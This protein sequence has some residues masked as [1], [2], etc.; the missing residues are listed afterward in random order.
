MFKHFLTII[1][2]IFS[3]TLINGAA[4]RVT[5]TNNT[6]G[7]NNVSF[8]FDIDT[9]NTTIALMQIWLD[10]SAFTDFDLS[11]PALDALGN[12]TLSGF[13]S[14]PTL[15]VADNVSKRITFSNCEWAWGTTITITL[16]A[17]VINNT[18][19]E[20]QSITVGSDSVRI[21]KGPVSHT[22]YNYV[23]ITGVNTVDSNGNGKI[24]RLR[25][26]TNSPNNIV[27]SGSGSFAYTVSGYT[28]A[29]TFV[30]N[31]TD[32]Y[33]TFNEGGGLD[34][35][36]TPA[37]TLSTNT[38]YWDAT[39]K[40]MVETGAQPGDYPATTDGAAPIITAAVTEDTNNDGYIDRITLTYYENVVSNNNWG[41]TYAGSSN[42]LTTSTVGAATNTV[43]LTFT[44]SAGSYDTAETP[45]VIYNTFSGNI[46]DTNGVAAP[47]QTFSATTDGAAPIII[48]SSTGD[49]NNDGYI[50]TITLTYSED[51]N[52]SNNSGFTYTGSTNTLTTSTVAGGASPTITLSYT[53][54]AG[55]Y[56]TEN[57]P[58]VVYAS[59]SAN[60]VDTSAATNGAPDQTFISTIDSAL[61]AV[62]DV[63]R[64]YDGGTKTNA[65]SI[66]FSEPI[67][68]GGMTTNGSWYASGSD[69]DLSDGF[70]TGAGLDSA[71]NF[72]LFGIG[73]INS[74]SSGADL[75]A[76]SATYNMYS[77]PADRESISIRMGANSGFIRTNGTEND[78]GDYF[79]PSINLKDDNG[80]AVYNP[81]GSHANYTLDGAASTWTV[82]NPTMTNADTTEDSL[83]IDGWINGIVI[84]FSTSVIINDGAADFGNSTVI[85]GAV[86]Y[87]VSTV[88]HSQT[89]TNDFQ[90]QLNESGVGNGDTAATPTITYVNGS[91]F[92]IY[93]VDGRV[94][95]ANNHSIV[96]N[97]TAH[98]VLTWVQF[99]VDD[100]PGI[101]YDTSPF[102]DQATTTY[103]NPGPADTY[104]M[105]LS[106]ANTTRPVTER[107]Y[108][109]TIRFTFSEDIDLTSSLGGTIPL[110]PQSGGY[111]FDPTQKSGNT[112]NSFGDTVI[113]GANQEVKGLGNIL[114]TNFTVTPGTNFVQF[115]SGFS[116]FI[117]IVGW[118][119]GTEFAGHILSTGYIP[120]SGGMVDYFRTENNSNIQDSAGNSLFKKNVAG[121]SDILITFAPDGALTKNW[122][123]YPPLFRYN[124]FTDPITSAPPAADLSHGVVNGSPV[125]SIEFVMT[126]AIRDPSDSVMTTELS[127]TFLDD[128][129]PVT[130]AINFSSTILKLGTL[131]NNSAAPSGDTDLNDQ[132]FSITFTPVIGKGPESRIQWTYSQPTA[133]S[134]IIT[135]LRGNRLA[136]V[137]VTRTSLESTAPYIIHTR[138]VPGS[139]QIYIEFN[140]PVF[141]SVGGTIDSTSFQYYDNINGAGYGITSLTPYDASGS[142]Y[143]LTMDDSAALYTVSIEQIIVDVIKCI[144][145]NE[146]VDLLGNKINPTPDSDYKVSSIG[147]NFFSNE[148]L[149][150]YFN[151]GSD[152]RVTE[153][154]GSQSIGDIDMSFQ[155]AVS[156]TIF[157]AFVPILFYDVT[158]STAYWSPSSNFNARSVVSTSLGNDTWQFLIPS[159]DSE[160]K[161][162]NELSMVLK[163][164]NYYC[165]RSKYDVG[166]P[167]FNPYDVEPYRVQIKSVQSQSGGVT[168][169]NNV[170]NPN[171]G[172]KTRVVYT[173]DKA[174]PVSVVVYD[175]SGNTVM[176]LK[177]EPQAAG[178]HVLTWNGHNNNGRVVARGVY[179]IRITA[180][181]I[182]NQIRKVLVVK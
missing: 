18:V 5:A 151:K 172:E 63:V 27:D 65:L 51:V 79:V 136:S 74:G 138:M 94:E 97:D 133:F 112:Q 85:D 168:I 87:T 54:S 132:A 125:D 101:N 106:T 114:A 120:V 4:P 98:P 166:H 170:I 34:T 96:A 161:S 123:V 157:P 164:G 66:I 169:L 99:G 80:N 115:E 121:N 142:R 148:L 64:S 42:T 140:E 103:G 78:T 182:S 37:F 29:D 128:G 15:V 70:G 155:A 35:D 179:F 174:G 81:G 147:V 91:T 52:R 124:N 49:S 76:I 162:G 176:V 141:N 156:S 153:F 152:W 26:T 127:L 45:D 47:S 48:S 28:D 67:N 163:I 39:R 6:V 116:L 62:V 11:D 53:N 33:V 68:W 17:V 2:L 111:N 122:D 12:Y 107:T 46:E 131:T 130:S 8:T 117:H 10:F 41:F 40:V 171:K 89:V 3:L 149:E 44:N 19:A 60:I 102:Y 110:D 135:D 100:P 84:D 71:S 50:D 165:Y 83:D 173:M 36:A 143:I 24:D 31:A 9:N 158:G 75:R 14:G 95:M 105:H 159:S 129:S 160:I 118:Y 57:T 73:S 13:T 146:I 177:H 16:P 72:T 104:N 134:R 144:N 23:Q 119:D 92:V 1:F 30:A 25:I 181:G 126:E 109:N 88:N 7:W 178:K 139:N 175:L 90:L 55:S 77:I 61:P 58:N 113:N 56:D 86:T 20:T 180:P 154:D 59:A 82:T 137:T 22:V 69:T 43:T 32:F 167:N 38:K 108:H 145:N 93:S 21:D 150:D